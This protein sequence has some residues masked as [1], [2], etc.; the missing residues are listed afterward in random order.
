MLDK[1]T[2]QTIFD[3]GNKANQLFESKKNSMKDSI[4]YHDDKTYIVI[5]KK[6]D[7]EL[8]TLLSE[9]THKMTPYMDIR[10]II[11]PRKFD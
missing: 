5:I 6:L 11:A 3:F 4:K 2:Y 10:D 8:D 9:V 1:K 7:N